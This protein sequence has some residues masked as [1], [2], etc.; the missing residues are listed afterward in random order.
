MS[1]LRTSLALLT[2]TALLS[3]CASTPEQRA[4]RALAQKREE[5]SLQ[6]YLAAQCDR[7]TAGLMQKQFDA[8]AIPGAPT[9]EQQAFRLRY[10][11]KVSDPMF[12]ACYKMAW[13]NHISQQQL[14]AARA[15]YYDDWAYPFRNPWYWW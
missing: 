5:Q 10:I 6:I 8:A 9:A 3:A 1:P 2:C 15:Y 11:D 13:Q 12:Q 14:R 7:E 4:A